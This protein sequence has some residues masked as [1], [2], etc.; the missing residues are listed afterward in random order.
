M[1]R[2]AKGYGAYMV[3]AQFARPMVA[4]IDMDEA[5]IRHATEKY[6]G[7]KRLEMEPRPAIR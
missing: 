4:G 5:V 2:A 6:Q 3:L 1:S 7:D